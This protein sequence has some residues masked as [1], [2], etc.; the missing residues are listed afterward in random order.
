MP[1][2]GGLKTWNFGDKEDY[3]EYVDEQ[4]YCVDVNPQSRFSIAQND[5]QM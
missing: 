5:G 3:L 4:S 2:G 1:W